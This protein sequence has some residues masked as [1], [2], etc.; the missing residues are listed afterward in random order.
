MIETFDKFLAEAKATTL[1]TVSDVKAGDIIQIAQHD[2]V[3]YAKIKIVKGTIGNFITV[4]D[5]SVYD[6]DNPS[7]TFKKVENTT[8]ALVKDQIR[9]IQQHCLDYKIGVYELNLLL[10]NLDNIISDIKP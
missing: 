9:L 6:L 7:L 1:K 3:W 10:L 2:K 8:P 5:G 4:E